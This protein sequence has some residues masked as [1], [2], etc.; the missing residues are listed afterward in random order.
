MSKSVQEKFITNWVT[1]I[2]HLVTWQGQLNWIQKEQ[3]NKKVFH[4][5]ISA[6]SGLLPVDWN[7][8]GSLITNKIQIA[9]THSVWQMIVQH[10]KVEILIQ[11]LKHQKHPMQDINT[12]HP[13]LM[14]RNIFQISFV[15]II[16]R[17]SKRS[18]KKLKFQIWA[19][20]NPNHIRISVRKYFWKSKRLIRWIWKI[21]FNFRIWTI[22]WM[23]STI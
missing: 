5:V 23:I 12:K 15:T 18:R 9:R 7:V 3:Q 21:L 19:G 8:S 4:S 13:M 16:C 17:V 14:L 22:C 1:I 2:Y 6:T 10:W 20:D 11:Q